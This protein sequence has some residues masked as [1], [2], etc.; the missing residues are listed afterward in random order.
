MK[1]MIAIMISAVMLAV[2]GATFDLGNKFHP[3]SATV[4]KKGGRLQVSCRFT[5]LKALRNN[6]SRSAVYND[7]KAR[8]LCMKALKLY[9]NVPGNTEIEVSGLTTEK[10]SRTTGTELEYYFS[11]PE[12]GISTRAATVKP[13]RS[14]SN[15]SPSGSV[16]AAADPMSAVATT[17]STAMVTPA[18]PAGKSAAPTAAVPAAKGKAYRNLQTRSSFRMIKYKISDGKVSV[19]SS[20][21]YRVEDFP[22]QKTFDNFCDDQFRRIAQE[23][24]K[25]MAEM[26]QRLKQELRRI[27]KG[28]GE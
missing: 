23:G 10:P 12:S 27:E 18:L 24:D 15:P 11:V 14:I 16:P 19:T 22:D 26:D 8:G 1:Q 6:P 9:M 7:Q 4:E 25:M 2:N 3:A 20:R 13:A 21:N 28:F 17:V 5:P